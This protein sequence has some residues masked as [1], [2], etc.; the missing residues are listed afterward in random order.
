MDETSRGG[1]TQEGVPSSQEGAGQPF[2]LTPASSP[3]YT[4]CTGCGRTETFARFLT[5]TFCNS[6]THIT[7]AR[8]PFT[9]SLLHQSN[10]LTSTTVKPTAR[11]DAAFS[12]QADHASPLSTKAIAATLT[13]PNEGRRGEGRATRS[14]SM[15]VGL[16]GKFFCSKD[17]AMGVD[18]VENYQWNSELSSRVEAAFQEEWGEAYA[19]LLHYHGIDAAD[20]SLP[21]FVDGKVAKVEGVDSV[22]TLFYPVPGDATLTEMDTFATDSCRLYC[23]IRAEAWERY[24][25]EERL[26]YGHPLFYAPPFL[27]IANELMVEAVTEL[28]SSRG[29]AARLY[30][31]DSTHHPI[32]S[33]V[34]VPRGILELWQSPAEAP[35]IAENESNNFIGEALS[36]IVEGA[37]VPDTVVKYLNCSRFGR[38]LRK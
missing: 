31:L 36:A 29:Q 18:V 21:K 3:Y 27:D 5:C 19:S 33:V 23:Q 24:F 10:V 8:D 12:A 11:S 4:A 17:C 22:E 7:C 2:S 28:T 15:P 14:G 38:I 34:A 13:S 6:R 26:Y 35:M 25:D 9:N 20:S 30:L 32:G 37:I 16:E 1:T